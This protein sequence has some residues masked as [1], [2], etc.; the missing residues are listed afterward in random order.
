MCL[1]RWWSGKNLTE[2]RTSRIR[3]R[4]SPRKKFYLGDL[5]KRKIGKIHQATLRSWRLI[6][7]PLKLWSLRCVYMRFICFR[8]M[9]SIVWKPMSVKYMFELFYLALTVRVQIVQSA[10]RK[11]H[12]TFNIQ[13]IGGENSSCSCPVSAKYSQFG[14]GGYYV[15]FLELLFCGFKVCRGI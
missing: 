10:S 12:T 15:V 3:A 5:M 13:W 14:Q 7:P 8:K 11:G 4:N 2:S 9:R 6:N 1:N